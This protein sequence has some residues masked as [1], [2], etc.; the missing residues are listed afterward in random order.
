MIFCVLAIETVGHEMRRSSSL[1]AL[2]YIQVAHAHPKGEEVHTSRELERYLIVINSEA[3]SLL[4]HFSFALLIFSYESHV[5]PAS[6]P[7]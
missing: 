2:K 4:R 5:S 6:F 3:K 1:R 7:H